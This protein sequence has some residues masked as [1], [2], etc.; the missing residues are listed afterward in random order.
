MKFG[1]TRRKGKSINCQQPLTLNLKIDR[2]YCHP[3][4]SLWMEYDE[5]EIIYG[6]KTNPSTDR[7]WSLFRYHDS[8]IKFIIDI[9]SLRKTRFFNKSECIWHIWNHL[10]INGWFWCIFNL[11]LSGSPS[12]LARIR[13]SIY[14]F[15]HPCCCYRGPRKYS[16]NFLMSI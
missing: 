2:D 11:I 4:V 8:V 16:R 5:K 15:N 7:Y 13:G 1:C 6:L 14:E 12:L 10:Y 9:D 3:I